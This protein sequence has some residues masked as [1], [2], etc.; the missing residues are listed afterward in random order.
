VDIG[1]KQGAFLHFSDIE[2]S[3]DINLNDEMKKS[4]SQ[5]KKG[6][7][8]LTKRKIVAFRQNLK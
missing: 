7:Q 8:L 3:P 1:T 6:N 5:R 2:S 4:K